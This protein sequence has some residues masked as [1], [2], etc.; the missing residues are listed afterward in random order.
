MFEQKKKQLWVQLGR[1]EALL[2]GTSPEVR[3]LK[4]YNFTLMWQ[5][6][7][8]GLLLLNVWFTV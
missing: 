8:G 4:R 3:N 7:G 5:Q 2:N 6:R 1:L